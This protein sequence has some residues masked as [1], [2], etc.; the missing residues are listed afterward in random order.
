MPF[1]AA[2]LMV[3]LKAQSPQ[4][5]D[6]LLVDTFRYRADGSLPPIHPSISIY[7]SINRSIF[8][9]CTLFSSL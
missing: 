8:I 2:S 5:I 3:L 7:L 6:G 4:A 1:N 9:H